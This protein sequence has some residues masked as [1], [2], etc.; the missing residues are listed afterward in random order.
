MSVVHS[1]QGGALSGASQLEASVQGANVISRTLEQLYGHEDNTVIDET[2]RSSDKD[3]M[4]WPA[5]I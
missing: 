1:V 4:N 2:E 3:M 5:L